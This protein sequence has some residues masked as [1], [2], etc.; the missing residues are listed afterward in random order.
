MSCAREGVAQVLLL[1]FIERGFQNSSTRILDLIEN[2]VRGE[3]LSA[4]E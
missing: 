4:I 3:G 1:L 2:L